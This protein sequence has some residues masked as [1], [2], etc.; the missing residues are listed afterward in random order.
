MMKCSRVFISATGAKCS[1]FCDQYHI[2]LTIWFHCSQ[3]LNIYFLTLNKQSESRYLL[4][5]KKCQFSQ[6]LKKGSRAP[7]MCQYPHNN[8]IQPIAGQWSHCLDFLTFIFCE[9]GH[10]DT[11]P[12]IWVILESRTI[13]LAWFCLCLWMNRIL[14]MSKWQKYSG[15]PGLYCLL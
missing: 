7:R 3:L 9:L 15:F 8:S 10:S 1:H 14:H 4:C 13:L 11:R 6:Y 12:V 5:K 2:A